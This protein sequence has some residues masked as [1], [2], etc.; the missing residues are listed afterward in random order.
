MQKYRPTFFLQSSLALA[1]FSLSQRVYLF[2]LSLTSYKQHIHNIGIRI[3]PCVARIQPHRLYCIVLCKMLTAWVIQQF[4][5]LLLILYDP[6]LY[7]SPPSAGQ[8]WL[9]RCKKSILDGHK[10]AHLLLVPQSIQS[11]LNAWM[12]CNGRIIFRD[13]TN[14]SSLTLIG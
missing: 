8:D 2:M 6:V 3:H 5:L 9:L 14:F 12:E 13:N 11:R 7:H 10:A 1:P 4:I